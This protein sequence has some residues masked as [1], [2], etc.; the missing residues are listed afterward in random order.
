MDYKAY[1]YT[2]EIVAM[3]NGCYVHPIT[4][5]IDLSNRCQ[6]NCKFCMYKEQR[7]E[8]NVDL[9]YAVYAT[10]IDDLARTG[11]KSVTFTGGGEPL[12]NPRA[13]DMIRLA[14]NAGLEMGMVTNGINLP[15]IPKTLLSQFKFIRISIDSA[16]QSTYYSVKGADH[17]YDVIDNVKGLVENF[18]H[19]VTIGLSFVICVLNEHETLEAERMAEELNVDYIQFKPA[20]TGEDVYGQMGYP[21]EDQGER[22]IVMNRYKPTNNLPCTIAALIGIVGADGRVYYCCQHRGNPN[23]CFGNLK[24]QAFH[25]IMLTRNT[26]EPDL[27]NCPQCRYMNYSK[28]FEEI[29]KFLIQHRHFL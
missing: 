12:M 13:E 10:L 28:K 20:W 3:M 5:E 19:D 7:K 27:T 26:I 16:C 24:A 1:F 15:K 9:D 25:T 22:T 21:E 29:P 6:L 11:V 17:Y 2:N 23:Y 4:C 18:K 8:A 14:A